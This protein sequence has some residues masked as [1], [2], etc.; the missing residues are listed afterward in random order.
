MCCYSVA[1]SN[2]AFA[3]FV[4]SMW[5]HA[6]PGHARR[7]LS[8]STSSS[9]VCEMWTWIQRQLFTQRG[10]NFLFARWFTPCWLAFA[11]Q[12][13]S[14]IHPK[15]QC[16]P[17][18]REF[19]TNEALQ[20]HYFA[21]VN[22]P[23]CSMCY[24]GFKDDSEYRS[25]GYFSLFLLL[26]THGRNQHMDSHSSLLKVEPDF[27]RNSFSPLILPIRRIQ[28]MDIGEPLWT[29]WTKLSGLHLTGIE[30]HCR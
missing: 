19:Q 11:I 9:D 29:W 3:G 15:L 23:E 21:S 1:S 28:V 2:R 27:D 20:N 24:R 25:V 30:P 16:D 14:S 17:C 22:H 26:V 10:S 8:N 4:S 6:A 13:E 12:H 18:E 5:N 7:S